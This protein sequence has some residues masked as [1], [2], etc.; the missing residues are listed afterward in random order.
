MLA[1][2]IM[3]TAGIFV[4]ALVCNGDK[5]GT[6]M[7]EAGASHGFQPEDQL[8]KL[9]HEDPTGIA[10]RS[11]E[12]S[13]EVADTLVKLTPS[14]V[15]ILLE[16]VGQ[17]T[18]DQLNDAKAVAEVMI[19]AVNLGQYAKTRREFDIQK[20]TNTVVPAVAE[21]LVRYSE[22]YRNTVEAE[23]KT[24]EQDDA[25]PQLERSKSQK[26]FLSL[27]RT[28]A[29]KGKNILLAVIKDIKVATPKVETVADQDET[30]E[31]A[32][33]EETPVAEVVVDDENT[34]KKRKRRMFDRIARPF[35]KLKESAAKARSNVVEQ[36]Q[37]VGRRQTLERQVSKAIAEVTK[38]SLE[39]VTPDSTFSDVRLWKDGKPQE[40]AFN[41]MLSNLKIPALDFTITPTA[42]IANLLFAIE[43]QHPELSIPQAAQ[44]EV[45]GVTFGSDLQANRSETDAQKI[46]AQEIGNRQESLRQVK[47]RKRS[48]EDNLIEVEK[49]LEKGADLSYTERREL[50]NKKDKLI[51][52]YQDILKQLR[53]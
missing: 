27:V 40:E 25:E 2:S 46:K 28:A 6:K 50:E 29:A 14:E 53:G 23:G 48:I 3:M 7:T 8:S 52:D 4:V 45:S 31:E 43:N 26:R 12:Y 11:K 21:M 20:L 32:Q 13:L 24:P 49:A 41:Q 22:D 15:K 39:S 47:K 38:Q 16:S 9:I 34:S 30:A 17:L 19:R 18:I 33:T 37:N 44:A 1:V 51:L 10:S 36:V 5:K 35:Q 42:T